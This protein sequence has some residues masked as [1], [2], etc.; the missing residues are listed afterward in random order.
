MLISGVRWQRKSKQVTWLSHVLSCCNVSV[1]FLIF[2]KMF[3]H[4]S[5]T[6]IIKL[7]PNPFILLWPLPNSLHGLE[8]LYIMYKSSHYRASSNDIKNVYTIRNDLFYDK[9]HG[10]LPLSER[11]CI[12]PLGCPVFCDVT[13]HLKSKIKFVFSN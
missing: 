8:R 10:A 13:K 7:T 11:N 6:I 1:G 3:T 5:I 2:M 4:C 9:L 12:L